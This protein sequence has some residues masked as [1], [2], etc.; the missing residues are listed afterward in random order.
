MSEQALIPKMKRVDKS[1]KKFVIPWLNI[2]LIVFFTLLIISSTFLNIN[3]KHYIIPLNLFSSEKLTNNDFIYSM[4]FIPQIPT[5]MFVC[6]VLGKKMS[7]TCTV[8]Y[9]LLGLF[10]L[11]IFA[12]GGGYKY[13]GEFGFG[14]TIGYIPAAIII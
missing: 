11:P 14:Y 6:S 13:I 1:K 10:A 7:I 3:L 2:A 5:I 4:Y 12:L 8:L 9:I